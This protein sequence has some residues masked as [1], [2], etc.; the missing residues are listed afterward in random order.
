MVITKRRLLSWIKSARKITCLR[1]IDKAV[2][3]SHFGVPASISWLY[4]VE[5]QLEQSW[6][7]NSLFWAFCQVHSHSLQKL[8]DWPR[9]TSASDYTSSCSFHPL[10]DQTLL[11]SRKF[12]LSITTSIKQASFHLPQ[13]IY[14]YHDTQVSEAVP[15]LDCVQLN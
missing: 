13:A 2:R 4:H 6:Y 1:P 15:P 14:F 5:S 8:T 3:S 10:P 12:L 11:L 9:E 7:C